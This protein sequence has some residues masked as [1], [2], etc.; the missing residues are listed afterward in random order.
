MEYQSRYVYK[1]VAQ[2]NDLNTETMKQEIEQEK[3]TEEKQVGKMKIFI[4]R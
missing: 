1:K 3:M 2:G 4:K